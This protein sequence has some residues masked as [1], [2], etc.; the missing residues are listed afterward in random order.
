MISGITSL[1]CKGKRSIAFYF[2]EEKLKSP[3]MLISEGW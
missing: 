3:R 2:Q 1:D